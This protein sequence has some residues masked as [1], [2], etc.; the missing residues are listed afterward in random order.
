MDCC[1]DAD[2]LRLFAVKLWNKGEKVKLWYGEMVL[3][4]AILKQMWWNGA[5]NTHMST[6]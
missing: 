2:F 1:S 5:D 4:R 3:Y 6:W